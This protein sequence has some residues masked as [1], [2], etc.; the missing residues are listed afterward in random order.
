[1]AKP[2]LITKAS[3]VK[4]PTDCAITIVVHTHASSRK[5]ADRHRMATRQSR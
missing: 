3:S 5:S 4:A 2:E 1:M